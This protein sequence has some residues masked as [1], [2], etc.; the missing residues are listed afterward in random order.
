MYFVCPCTIYMSTKSTAKENP[1][2]LKH[3]KKAKAGNCSKTHLSQKSKQSL[4]C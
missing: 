2:A 3:K 4:K 1:N